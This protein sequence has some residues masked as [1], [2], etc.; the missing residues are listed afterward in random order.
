MSQLKKRITPVRIAVAR[1]ELTS[2]TP[3]FARTAVA[4]ANNAES[5]AQNNHS[6]GEEFKKPRIQEAKENE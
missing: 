1:F 2:A 5:T 6:I 3:I 4:P